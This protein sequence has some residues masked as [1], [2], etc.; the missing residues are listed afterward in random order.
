[1]DDLPDAVAKNSPTPVL[2]EVGL[3]KSKSLKLFI[4]LRSKNPQYRQN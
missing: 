4:W 3:E 1:M 2:G